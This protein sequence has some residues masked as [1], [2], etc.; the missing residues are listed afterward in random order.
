MTKAGNPEGLSALCPIWNW[1][2]TKKAPLAKLQM[3]LS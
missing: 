3:T 2:E 1:P